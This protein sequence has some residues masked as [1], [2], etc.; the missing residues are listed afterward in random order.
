VIRWE[1][2]GPY[3]VLFTTRRGGVSEGS[4]ASLN[5]GRKTGDDVERVD[6]NRRRACTEIE[7]DPERL[8]LN[9]QVHSAVVRRAREGERGGVRADGLWTE[10]PGLPVLALSA[11]CLPVALVRVNG[12]TPA[13]CVLHAGRIGLLD[14]ILEAGVT[15][16]GGT[17]A[18][19]IGPA[20]GPCCYEVG[21]EVATPYRTRFGAEIMRGRKLDLWQ[22]A[23]RV[24]RDAGVERVERFDLC[25][26][27]NPELFFSHRRDGKPRG[28]QGV[29]ARVS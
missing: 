4:Y 23:E 12:A 1:V 24:L 29:L 11:D 9:Y 20:I 28:V 2:P 16:L 21:E 19:A 6:E 5:L 13:V 22:A 25:T 14:G 7:A 15:A 26:A 3:E 18:A 17:L 10:A 27:C 8:A